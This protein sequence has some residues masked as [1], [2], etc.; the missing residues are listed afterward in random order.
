MSSRRCRPARSRRLNLIL[1]A[2]F[3]GSLEPIV[4]SLNRLNGE[5]VKIKILLRG[6][7]NISE[8]DIT[9]ASASHAIVI[10]FNVQPDGAAQKLADSQGVDIRTYDVIYNLIEDVEPGPQGN[11]RTGLP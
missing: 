1:K 6:T 3:Q 7:G 9:L 8:S 10:G 2:D 4:N 11:A 5:E